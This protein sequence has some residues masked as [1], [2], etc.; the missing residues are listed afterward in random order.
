MIE[1]SV[2]CLRT[3]RCR[4]FVATPEQEHGSELDPESQTLTGS[5][6]SYCYLSTYDRCESS[7][8]SPRPVVVRKGYR[9]Y[10]MRPGNAK[11]TMSSCFDIC[12]AQKNCHQCGRPNCS[13]TNCLECKRRCWE[14]TPRVSGEVTIMDALAQTNTVR[15]QAEWQLLWKEEFFLYD[16]LENQVFRLK[17]EIAFEDMET[18]VSYFESSSISGE[19]LQVG[20][21]LM[22]EG[23]AGNGWGAPFNREEHFMKQSNCHKFFIDKTE[24]CYAAGIPSYK[25]QTT[26]NATT[27]K[28]GYPWKEM[29]E[30]PLKVIENISLWITMS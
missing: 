23:D 22:T 12:L 11:D 9:T 24:P 5:D 16:G 20:E 3:P 14:M 21:Y 10:E 13:G 7:S 1:C 27:I 30:E 26:R 28:R 18:R 17:V 15:C 25:D 2:A 19:T 4:S 29:E 8:S 6:A